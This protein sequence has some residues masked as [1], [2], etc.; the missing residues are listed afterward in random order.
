[1]IGQWPARQICAEIIETVAAQIDARQFNRRFPRRC[2]L[3][4]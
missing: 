4:K 1:V 3:M 2:N